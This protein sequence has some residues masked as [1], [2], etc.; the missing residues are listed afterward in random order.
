MFGSAVRGGFGPGHVEANLLLIV[1]DASTTALRPIERAIA[2]WVKRRFPAPLIFTE[3]E[4]RASTDVFPI[5]IE[6]M[7]EAHELLRGDN[8]F[9]GLATNR[10]HLRHELEREIRGKLLQLRAERYGLAEG[11]P[12]PDNRAIPDGGATPP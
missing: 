12:S 10:A 7:R 4:W 8:P 6:D 5:E 1:K 3:R 2:D 9:D 11:A